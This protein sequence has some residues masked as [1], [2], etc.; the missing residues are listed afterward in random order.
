MSDLRGKR[1]GVEDTAL[2]DYVLARALQVHGMGDSEITPVSLTVDQTV[3]AFKSGEVDAVVTFEP[4]KSSITKLGG[5]K[6]FDSSEIP[7]E[8]VDVLVVH[9]EFARQNPAA[10]KAV[11]RGW[12]QAAE[13]RPRLRRQHRA[14]RSGKPP[15]F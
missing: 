3:A 12:L 10:V 2:G 7:D 5:M 14:F 1:I 6:V 8:V 13:P 11:V 15:E 9:S 4:F